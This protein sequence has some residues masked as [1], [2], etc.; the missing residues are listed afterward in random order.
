MK[1]NGRCWTL[2]A[3]A[4]L[5]QLAEDPLAVVLRDDEAA[6]LQR[7]VGLDDDDVAVGELRHHAVADDT[8]RED[9]AA[10]AAA[11]EAGTGRAGVHST[12]ERICRPGTPM[13][14]SVSAR[15]ATKACGPAR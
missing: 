4:L 10:G 5:T 8:Q 2:P 13:R 15:V 3:A 6:V 1:S 7:T 9:L 12:S 14:A 11:V